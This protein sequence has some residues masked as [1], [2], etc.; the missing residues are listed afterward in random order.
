MNT[1]KIITSVVA[2][3]MGVA[4]LGTVAVFPA[5]AES[6]GVNA[7]TTKAEK[8]QANTTARLQKIISRSDTAITARISDLNNLNTKVQAMKNVSATEK[9]S[10][11]TEI[12][13]NISGLTA[14]K[15]KI[16]ADTDVNVALSD[17]KIITGNFRIYAL[18]VPRGHVEASADRVSTIV[19]MMQTIATKLQTR[20]T[21]DQTAGKDVAVLQSALTDYNAKIADAQVQATKAQ[22]EV[23]SL[24]PDN[25]NKTQ[26]A[27]N[28]AAL[29]TAREYIK[30]A[31][32]DLH[33]ARADA[34][35]I[36]QGLKTLDKNT[37]AS[38]TTR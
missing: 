17:E 27:S 13:T 18:I 32:A 9:A 3:S 8:A 31:T 6:V 35:T 12:Q 34:K 15:A 36:L 1:K 11:S 23:A 25:G 22:S 7:S 37:T 4:L 14:L 26:L 10:L 30:T 19:G 21:A 29:K 20:I 2:F 24:V 5:Y 38:T 33:T 28:T 16:D